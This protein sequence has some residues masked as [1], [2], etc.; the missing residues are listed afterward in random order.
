M[1]GAQRMDIQGAN[2]FFQFVFALR[3]A[4][5]LRDICLLH[6]KF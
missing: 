3:G 4:A 6:R 2:L 5:L 1:K